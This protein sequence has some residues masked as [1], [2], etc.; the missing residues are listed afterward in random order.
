MGEAQALTKMRESLQKK[1]GSS[2][3][4][5]SDAT[6]TRFLIA[7]S[8]N[9]EKAAKMLVEWRKWRASMVPNGGL[10][11]ECEIAE[12]LEARKL[13]LQGLSQDK[14]PVLIV[15]ASKHFPSKDHIQ[16]K[17]YVVYLLDKT[18]ASAIKG[19]EI[20]NEKLIGILDLQHISYRNIDVRGFITGFQF[21]QAYYPER[22]A[23]LYVINMPQFFVSVWK[24][25]CRFLEKATLEKK[26]QVLFLVLGLLH[27][28][29]LA[30]L[31][32]GKWTVL[33]QVMG[34]KSCIKALLEH[35][36]ESCPTGESLAVESL[37][38]TATF[39]LPAL[40][41]LSS[42]NHSGIAL[43]SSIDPEHAIFT[44]LCASSVTTMW[45][46]LFTEGRGR[47]L[48]SLLPASRDLSVSAHDRV[49]VHYSHQIS[50]PTHPIAL[51]I[52]PLF[53]VLFL[54]WCFDAPVYET[55]LLLGFQGCL[56]SY[57]PGK[58]V[59]IGNNEDERKQF[60]KDIG[61]E[62]LP[63][64]YGGQAQLVALQDVA[65]TITPFEENATTN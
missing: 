5:Y 65:L 8:M 25:I 39:F 60:V 12:E 22:L 13:F 52:F 28:V 49:L 53:I 35:I 46:A 42:L 33:R 64:E 3:E 19:R 26:L 48:W 6:L 40:F 15:Q 31:L 54:L 51:W 61:E 56:H 4:M 21:L 9:A 30:V 17:K 37:T 59:I 32:S 24:L 62:V 34:S 57:A 38:T 23:K 11:S 47:R 63:Q 29:A 10:V 45:K 14:Y 43:S 16:F 36:S 44:S 18:I 58:I 55:H 1:L 20:G 2:S 50:L 27:S 7:R 41:S